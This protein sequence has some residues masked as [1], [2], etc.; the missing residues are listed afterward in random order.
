DRVAL[1]GH[2]NGG[3]MA[4]RAACDHAD[5]VRLVVSVAGAMA[6]D[7]AACAPER[8]VSVV[9]AHGTADPVVSFDGGNLAD[10][11]L[12]E[13]AAYPSAADSVAAWARLDRCDD[14]PVAAGT[15]DLDVGLPGAETSVAAYSGCAGD[16][17]V[18]LWTIDGGI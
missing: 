8:P 13:G 2:S 18:E 3:F 7:D 15:L 6:A 10:V 4:Y 16:V 5:L 9:Q 1:V 11:G 12:P 14:E 17:R